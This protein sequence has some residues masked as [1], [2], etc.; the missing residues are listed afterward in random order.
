MI[1]DIFLLVLLLGFAVNGWRRGAIATLSQLVS[2]IVSF[3][4][5]RAVYITAA[6]WLSIL[7][8]GR[9]ELAQGLSFLAVFLLVQQLCRLV[10]SLLDAV[11]HLLTIVPFVST[12]NKLIGLVLGAAVGTLFIGGAVYASIFLHLDDRWVSWLTHARVGRFAEMVFYRA[13]GFLL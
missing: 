9:P 10:L 1:A 13:L 7:L 2:I 8:P 5:A 12:I 6:G 3:F 11:F 4:V